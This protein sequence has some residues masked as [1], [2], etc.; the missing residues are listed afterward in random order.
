VE[1]GSFDKMVKI[2]NLYKNGYYKYS[3][4]TEI[5]EEKAYKYSKNLQKNIILN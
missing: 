1:I 3:R 5:D 4:Y 2:K